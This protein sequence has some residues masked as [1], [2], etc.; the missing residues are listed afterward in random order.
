M[1]AMRKL[2]VLLPVLFIAFTVYCQE[3]TPSAPLTKQDYLQKS[4]SQKTAAWILLGVGAGLVA[5]AA[6]GTVSFDILPI[7]SIGAA[8]A[9]I[10][11]IPLFISAG[12][13]KR[14]GMAMAINLN[15]QHSPVNTY[16]GLVK[17]SLPGIAVKLRL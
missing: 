2:V 4:K 1:I 13:N 11:S 17:H 9:I 5:V 14:K 15:M 10:G 12:K 16:S 3:V 7:L 6:P 8:A